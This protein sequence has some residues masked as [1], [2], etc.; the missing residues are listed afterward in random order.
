MPA[1]S[2]ST[3]ILNLPFPIPDDP[4]DVPR[5]IRAL[6]MALDIFSPAPP[7][8]TVLPAGPDD[9][10]EAHYLADDIQGVVWHLRYRAASTSQFKWEFLGGGALAHDI[11]TQGGRNNTA[12]GDTNQPVGGV[13]PQITLPL[14]GDYDIAHGAR[15]QAIPGAP[16]G[17]AYVSFAI[18]AVAASD[19]NS[20]QFARLVNSAGEQATSVARTQRLAGLAANTSLVMQYRNTGGGQHNYYHRWMRATPVRVG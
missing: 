3:P 2:G 10:Q 19:D 1:P 8:V 9:G 20:V 11:P 18:G 5:D 15:I 16:T 12:Y 6:A 14:A 13:G 7:L 17:I 4:V